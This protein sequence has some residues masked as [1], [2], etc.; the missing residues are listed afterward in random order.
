MKKDLLY[1]WKGKFADMTDED[2]TDALAADVLGWKVH[3]S[4][5]TPR[6]QIGKRWIEDWDFCPVTDENHFRIV[7]KKICEDENQDLQLN[8]MQEFEECIATYME[9]DLRTR[10]EAALRAELNCHPRCMHCKSRLC[11][12]DIENGDT[13]C[14]NCTEQFFD[15]KL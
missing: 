11:E 15:Q 5:H 9:S 10:C 14:F 7:L 12:G 8:F 4:L 6:F 2:L 13:F 1:T 3:R